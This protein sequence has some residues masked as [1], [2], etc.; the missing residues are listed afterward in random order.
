MT[1]ALGGEDVGGQGLDR[2]GG[3][4]VG[5]RRPAPAPSAG[6]LLD[7]DLEDRLL[8]VGHH[9]PGALFEQGL[10]DAPADAGRAPGHH[11]HLAA[12]VFHSVGPPIIA[13]VGQP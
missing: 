6:Q 7:R 10:G 11:G 1:G 8:D 9:D 5:A 3:G 4:D 13:P 12:Q 2:F